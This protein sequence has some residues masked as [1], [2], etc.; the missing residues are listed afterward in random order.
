MT[1][2]GL[3]VYFN[4]V[5]G[6]SFSVIGIAYLY[7][8]SEGFEELPAGM[9]ALAVFILFMSSSVTDTESGITISTIINKNWTAGR[10]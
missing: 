4:Q 8:K 3:A 9:I 2:S 6:A 1:E 5:Y 10:C 7:V